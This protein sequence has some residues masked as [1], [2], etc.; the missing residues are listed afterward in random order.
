MCAKILVRCN[1]AESI[2]LCTLHHH[3]EGDIANYIIFDKPNSFHNPKIVRS[4]FFVQSAFTCIL[5]FRRICT[6]HIFFHIFIAH[7]ALPHFEI[8]GGNC[9]EKLFFTKMPDNSKLH[10]EL[11]EQHMHHEWWL[12]A[13]F[14]CLPSMGCMC[15]CMRVAP[16][17]VHELLPRGVV[18]DE[19]RIVPHPSH[20]VG[21]LRVGGSHGLSNGM[22]QLPRRGACT[23]QTARPRG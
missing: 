8:L 15:A 23:S 10:F 21:Q 19:L 7:F 5:K 1:P 17:P 3:L 16:T 22:A 4:C 11:F 13:C 18:L 2:H 14:T 20:C 6:L 12:Y 9:K